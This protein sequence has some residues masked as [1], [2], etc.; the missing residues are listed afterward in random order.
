MRDAEALLERLAAPLHELGDAQPRGVRGDDGAPAE[1]VD[2]RVEL[3]LDGEVFDDGLD[4]DVALRDGLG[5]VV[6]EVA[7]EI[8][9]SKRGEKNAAGLALRAPSR[10]ASAILLRALRSP[11]GASLG[12]MSSSRTRRPAFAR[13]AAMAAPMTPAPRTVTSLIGSVVAIRPRYPRF[14]RRAS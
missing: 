13:C 7:V 3:L 4:D 11:A 10:P 6:L 12:G 14:T 5:Q 8:S 9:A 1:L 2:A